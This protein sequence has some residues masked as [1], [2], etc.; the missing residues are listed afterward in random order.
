MDQEQ[1]YNLSLSGGTESLKSAT[2][3]GF[4]S[5]DGVVKNTGFQRITL[6]SNND[7]RVNDKITIGLNMSPMYQLYATDGTDGDRAILSGAMIADPCQ[8]P[9]DENGNLKLELNS[10]GMFRQVNWVRANRERMDKYTVF[11][12]L[13]NAEV[14]IYNTERIL[15]IS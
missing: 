1:N 11:T 3:L 10:P 5:Q 8:A 7:Y 14:S 13:A 2:T 9:Y 6:R 15:L 4:F 12:L